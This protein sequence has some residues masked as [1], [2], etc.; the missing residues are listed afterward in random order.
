VIV[1]DIEGME[2]EEVWRFYNQRACVENM[3]KEGMTDY[4]L[5]A[6]VFHYCGANV[7]HF[8]LVMLAYNL[9]NWFK[10]GVLGQRKMERITKWIRERFIYILGKLIKRGRKWVLNLWQYYPWQEEHQ[11]HSIALAL[12]SAYS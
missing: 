12:S 7:A 5:D 6:A 9:M 10:E 4:G 3:I 11:K 8:F 1:T 2:P